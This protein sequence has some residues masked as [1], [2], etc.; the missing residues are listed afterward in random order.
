MRLN[1]YTILNALKTQNPNF[2]QPSVLSP[3]ILLIALVV[4][5]LYACTLPWVNNPGAAL[6]LSA[7]DLAEWTSLV[8]SVR[9][10]SPPLLPTVLLRLPLLILSGV[11]AFSKG[12]RVIRAVIVLTA[13][14]ALLPPLNFLQT[15]D[16]INYRQQFV[17][18]VLTL[19]SGGIGVSDRLGRWHPVIAPIIALL[20]GAA[21]LI[22][23]LQGYTLMREYQLPAQVGLGGIIFSGCCLGLALLTR[24]L[25]ARKPPRTS[26]NEP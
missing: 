9:G 17:L 25:T 2:T 18:A 13:A 21:A 1:N 15:P 26:S 22:G 8:P 23:V 5:A 14:V 19:I 10:G 20:G 16:D 3:Q 24:Q 11:I 7:Y 12:N 4:L 6:R